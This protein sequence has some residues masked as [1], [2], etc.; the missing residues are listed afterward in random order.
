[1][2]TPLRERMLQERVLRE[3]ELE[4]KRIQS[5]IRRNDAEAKKMEADAKSF[6]ESKL[7]VFMQH[8]LSAL[9]GGSLI[10]AFG[11]D[12]FKNFYELKIQESSLLSDKKKELEKKGREIEKQYLEVLIKDATLNAYNAYMEL[13]MQ[14]VIYRTK[15][16]TAEKRAKYASSQACRFI[17]D[18]WK[19][20]T[21]IAQETRKELFPEVKEKIADRLKEGEE[22]DLCPEECRRQGGEQHLSPI[23]RKSLDL[24]ERHVGEVRAGR[25]ELPDKLLSDFRKQP[26]FINE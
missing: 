24:I 20:V 19:L 16:D 10:V 26:E 15:T 12:T 22:K 14:Q 2:I 8:F 5:E 9:I 17:H 3:S 21:R 11:L 6:N 23:R 13:A 25:S 7:S 4:Q 1:M 18:Y